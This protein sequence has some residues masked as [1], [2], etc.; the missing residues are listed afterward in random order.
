MGFNYLLRGLK[1]LTQPGL[2]LFVII[3]LLI[4]ITIFTGLVYLTVSQFAGWIDSVINWLPSWLSFIADF[5]EWI[6]WPIVVA[7]LM[8]VVSYTFSIIANLIAAPF[9]SLLAEKVEE[10]LTG[11][12]VPG[13]ET[14]GQAVLGLPKGIARE[15]LK[16]LYYLPRLL[17]VFILTLLLPPIAPVLWFLLGAWM[18]AI[19]YCDYPM[20]NHQTRFAELK[21]KLK[22]QRMT[23]L[24]FG[25]AVM[26]GTMIPIVNFIIMPAAVCG[27]TVY[28]VE[29]LKDQSQEV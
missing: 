11:Q 21:R 22:A 18:M 24:G 1:L 15:S 27:A 16:I 25:S 2:R 14:I 23:S 29:K 19:E 8:I 20:D 7:F 9:N 10:K 3:P 12:E 5:L 13:Y 28:W 26:L 17:A 4:N 6:L